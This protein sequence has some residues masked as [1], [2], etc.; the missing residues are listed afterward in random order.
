M[1]T[2]RPTDAEAAAGGGAIG[3]A[4]WG[5]ITDVLPSGNANVV[6]WEADAGVLVK[7][8]IARGSA[9]GTFDTYGAGP[10]SV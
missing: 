9:K 10:S 5:A 2:Y 7:A 8:N 3:D 6:V 1:V 4:W